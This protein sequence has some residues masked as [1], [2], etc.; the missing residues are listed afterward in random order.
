[1]CVHAQLF[2]VEHVQALARAMYVED[3]PK[4]TGKRMRAACLAL[5]LKPEKTTAKLFKKLR[6]HFSIFLMRD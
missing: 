2:K 3:T 6:R 1:M 4:L 5:G